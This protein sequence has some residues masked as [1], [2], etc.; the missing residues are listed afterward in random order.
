MSKK[1]KIKPAKAGHVQSKSA[2]K[3]VNTKEKGKI[4]LL[5]LLPILLFTGICFFPMLKNQ[6]TNWDDEYYVVQNALLRGPDWT[7]IFSKPIVSNYHPITIATLAA[8]YS[9]TGLDASSYLITNLLLHLINTGLVFYFIWLISGKKLWAAAFTA[10]VFGIH[11]MHVE[12]VAWV[13]E[14]KDVLYTLFFLISLIQYW[15]F[16]V[17]SKSKYLIYCFLFFAL[18]LLSKPAA[19]ILPFVLV[20]LDYWYGRPIGKRSIFEKIPF[21]FLALVFAVI[22]VKLQSKTAIASLDFYPLWSRFFFATYT[23][24]MYIIRFFVPYPLSTFHPF[25]ATKTL[26]WPIMLSPLFMVALLTLIWFKRKNKLLVFSFFFFM[27][28]LALV[29]QIVSIGGTLLAERYTY[30]PYIGIGFFIGMM[31]D[32]YSATINKSLLWGVS[33]TVVLVFGIITFQRTKVWKDSD[34]LWT[35]VLEH[36]PNSSVPRTNRANYLIRISSAPENK[37]RQD[38]LLQ[39]ALEDC[40]EALKVPLNHA[41]AYENRQNIYLRLKKDSLALSDANSLINLEPGNR[42][43]WYT[44]GVAYQRLNIPDSALK[45]FNKCLE[46]NPNTDFALNNRGSL[47]F[48]YYKKYNEAMADFTK[49]IQINPQGDYYL[50]RSYC[51][52]QLGQVDLAKADV[53]VAIQKNIAIPDNYK[54]LLKL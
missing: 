22:T 6:L 8:N 3:P 31:L 2:N 20:L 45:Y 40:N 10:I 52:Y 12:S 4:L 7:G 23:S 28:N 9:M 27:I 26:G 44:K 17:T 30:V 14:R 54:Q 46:I 13:S 35:N 16:L 51:Y 18:S 19:I 39:R 47:L 25:P 11:P 38:E 1:K 21:L 42:L 37:G 15:R 50:N 41:K 24:M 32:K 34:T 33:G 36:F 48:N 53:R 5:W 43:G 49:A 29:L